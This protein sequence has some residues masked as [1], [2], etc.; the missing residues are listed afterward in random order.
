ML[1]NGTRPDGRAQGRGNERKHAA[2]PVLRFL[3]QFTQT[4]QGGRR[5]GGLQHRELPWAGAQC[6]R[7]MGDNMQLII[8][9]TRLAQSRAIHLSGA[10]LVA[11]FLALL[12]VLLLLCAGFYHWVF[13]TGAREG[14]P[15]VGPLVRL[16]AADEMAQRDRYVREN[17]DLLARKLG[18]MQ[19]RMQQLESLGQRVSGLAGINPAELQRSPGQGGIQIAGPALTMEELQTT[20]QQLDQL[21]HQRTDLMTVLE[22]RLIEQKVKT[23]TVPTQ[24]PVFDA[25]LGSPFGWRVD[26]ITGH[27]ALHTG[28]DFA[29]LS[30]TPILAAAGG[31]VVTQEYQT[32]YGNMVEIDHGNDLITRYAHASRVFV[33]K[34]DLIRRG[35]HIA[36][37]GST[38][39]STG[40]HL[41][42]EV[43]V[44]GVP[45]DPQKFL[46]RDIRLAGMPKS[47]ALGAPGD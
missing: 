33:R 47:T 12:L 10:R 45:Q 16:V 38:G 7:E 34:G 35:Q 4:R 46:T 37:V 29:A 14:W 41:H 21:T 3:R 17:I 19:A 42:F 40:P 32:D 22:S 8:T 39:R 36:D 18:D 27:M 44:R 15:V 23:M 13:L 1:V 20:L 9:D 6:H 25:A 28:L 31:V 24:V 30:G 26:P 11:A 43:L 2:Q 5:L